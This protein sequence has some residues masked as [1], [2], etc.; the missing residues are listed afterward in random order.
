MTTAPETMLTIGEVS[1]QIGLSAHTLRFYEQEGLFEAR[2]NAAGR[3]VFTGQDVGWLKVCT[4][5]RSSGMSLPD[6][7]RYAEL[8]RQGSGNEPNG[9]RSCVGTRRRC[10]SR[11]PTSGKHW[12]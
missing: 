5:L 6:I 8:A 1:A 11:W 7:R 9:S 4:K 3:R 2:R 10:G 12:T